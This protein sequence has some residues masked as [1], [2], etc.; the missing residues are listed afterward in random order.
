MVF[1]VLYTHFKDDIMTERKINNIF[2]EWEVF[3]SEIA[4][5]IPT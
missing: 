2:Y 3:L 1:P 5:Y 4:A